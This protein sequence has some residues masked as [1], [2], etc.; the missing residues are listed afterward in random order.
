V[1]HDAPYVRRLTA[2]KRCKD[3][4]AMP[5][6]EYIQLAVTAFLYLCASL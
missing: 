5:R 2:E 4:A 1:H 3:M 6:C